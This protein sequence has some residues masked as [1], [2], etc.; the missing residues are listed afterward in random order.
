MTADA[1]GGVWTYALELS[2]VFSQRGIEVILA[3]MGPPPGP[4]QRRDAAAIP[5]L[6]LRVGEYKLEWMSD[7]WTDIEAAGEWL[8]SLENETRPD[9]IHLNGYVHAALP[10][11]APKIVVGHSCVLS[12]WEA[13]H[14]EPTPESWRVYREKVTAGLR[15]ADTVV[16]PSYAMLNSLQLHYGPLPCSAVIPNGR[17]PALFPPAEKAPMI[18]SAGRL[19][20]QAKNVAALNE[21]ASDLEWPLYTAGT[22]GTLGQ[23]APAV[24]AGWLGRA[25]IYALPARYEPFGLSILEAALAGCALL[26]GDIPSLRENWEGA[27]LFAPP[28]NSSAILSQLRVLIRSGETRREF[29][30][31]ARARALGL[32]PEK[33][34]AAYLECYRLGTPNA[35]I[36]NGVKYDG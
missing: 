15:A 30:R 36:T 23:L 20:D 25:A 8:L 18:F 2:R 4:E 17:D 29:Q 32:T 14:G 34:A 27:A 22:G 10:W 13:V 3:V 33:M 1:V 21:I 26:L 6:S 31:A 16:T 7:P 12:W 5:L 24:L 19:W 9:L 28:E 35:A 11:R